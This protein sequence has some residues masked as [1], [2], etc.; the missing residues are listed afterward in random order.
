MSSR[1]ALTRADVGV[2]RSDL[3]PGVFL[4][5]ALAREQ[6]VVES[7]LGVV[8]LLR[9]RLTDLVLEATDGRVVLFDEPLEI[10]HLAGDVVA[11]GC[12]QFVL[13]ILDPLRDVVE[14]GH[15]AG[16]L[17]VE[18]AEVGVEPLDAADHVGLLVAEVGEDGAG[19]L[20]HQA[21]ERGRDIVEAARLARLGVGDA[22]FERLHL[23]GVDAVATAALLAQ[24]LDLGAQFR[25]L[26]LALVAQS[27]DFGHDCG[28]VSLE[29]GLHCSYQA[30]AKLVVLVAHLVTI[31]PLDRHGTRG[32]E[33]LR[34][35]AAGWIR[36][37]FDGSHSSYRH[38]RQHLEE[39]LTIPNRGETDSVP[40]AERGP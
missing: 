34:R 37:S 20:G 22:L 23:A 28:R 36:Q 5:A 1:P 29:L 3:L 15:H 31:L 8:D 19:G 12:A 6:P 7:V 11:Q 38:R 40:S 9:H 21:L 30:P 35:P 13:A 24:G 33:P 16:G 14:V 32:G 27:V 10:G 2:D 39:L 18:L 26:S 25:A 17:L 4:G